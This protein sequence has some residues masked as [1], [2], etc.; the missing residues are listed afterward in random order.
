MF[1][2]PGQVQIA[3]DGTNNR[4]TAEFEAAGRI[5][6]EASDGETLEVMIANADMQEPYEWTFRSIPLK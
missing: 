3:I 4:L 6:F 5:V 1:N 2:P